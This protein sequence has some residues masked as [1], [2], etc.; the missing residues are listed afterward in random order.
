[1]NGVI[2]HLLTDSFP[3]SGSKI[4]FVVKIPKGTIFAWD[5]NMQSVDYP[6]TLTENLPSTVFSLRRVGISENLGEFLPG[7]LA[8]GSLVT[9][10]IT[11]IGLLTSSKRIRLNSNNSYVTSASFTS[12]RDFYYIA[13]A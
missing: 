13:Y 3:E 12:T 4:P 5:E 10:T 11:S 9:L 6:W 1:M 2:N 8:N 7:K